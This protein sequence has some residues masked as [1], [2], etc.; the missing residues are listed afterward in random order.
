MKIENF[1]ERV[2]DFTISNVKFVFCRSLS[3]AVTAE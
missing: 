2:K 3:D 1:R